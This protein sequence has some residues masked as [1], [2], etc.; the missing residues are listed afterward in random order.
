[1]PGEVVERDRVPVDVLQVEPWRL[2]ARHLP[3]MRLGRRCERGDAG[4]LVADHEQPERV[5]DRPAQQG[6]ARLAAAQ[7]LG[8]QL[9]GRP[10][11]E[12]TLF[13]LADVVEQSAG[14]FTPE[15]WW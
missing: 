6:H 10:F 15:R 11:D 9:I 5:G 7:P 1:M 2:A 4:F 12:Q 3:A 14:R 13:S 8:L